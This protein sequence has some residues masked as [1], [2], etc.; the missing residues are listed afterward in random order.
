MYKLYTLKCLCKVTKIHNLFEYVIHVWLFRRTYTNMVQH[1]ERLNLQHGTYVGDVSN[2]KPHGNGTMTFKEDDAAERKT[3][4]G[5]WVN[6]KRTGHGT[7]TWRNGEVGFQSPQKSLLL[8]FVSSLW[9]WS[10]FTRP[11]KSLNVGHCI[12]S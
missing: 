4:Q 10:N 11:R 5:S 8:G 1:Q 12:S 6:G 9:L 7:M 3:Y 2:G